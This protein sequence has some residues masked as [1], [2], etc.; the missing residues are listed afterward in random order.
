MSEGGVH[1][2]DQVPYNESYCPSSP[3]APLARVVLRGKN[4]RRELGHELATRQGTG[5][6]GTVPRSNRHVICS[7][8]VDFHIGVKGTGD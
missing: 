6:L 4:T 2:S 8:Q 3:F 5:C 7:P 1:G